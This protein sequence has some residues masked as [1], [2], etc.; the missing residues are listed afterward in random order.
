MSMDS[1]YVSLAF[2]LAIGLLIG[3]E[4]GWQE[5]DGPEGSRSAGFRTIALI[6]VTGGVSGLLKGEAAGGTAAGTA[7]GLTPLLAIGYWQ[8]ATWHANFSLTTEVAAVLT[9]LLGLRA[10]AGHPSVAATAA[11]VVTALL[12]AKPELHALLR[13]PT[14]PDVRALLQLLLLAVVLLPLLPAGGLGPLELL[15]PIRIVV[16]VLLVASL[17]LAGHIAT[18]VAGPP[19]HPTSRLQAATV[20]RRGGHGFVD[21]YSTEHRIASHA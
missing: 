21:A 8:R 3:I 5:R 11:F 2:A 6:G 10:S 16:V 15:N 19:P 18:R 13:R 1:R 4:R 7:L 20:P 9:L 12:Q 17:S 14:A